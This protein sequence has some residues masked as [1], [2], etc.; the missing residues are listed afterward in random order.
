MCNRCFDGEFSR[1]QGTSCTCVVWL[2]APSSKLLVGNVLSIYAG[3]GKLSLAPSQ[4]LHGSPLWLVIGVASCDRRHYGL[5]IAYISENVCT[6]FHLFCCSFTLAF[7]PFCCSCSEPY[8]KV[9]SVAPSCESLLCGGDKR[10][11]IC[12]T[13]RMQMYFFASTIRVLSIHWACFGNSMAF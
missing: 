7:C 13:S 2:Y 6:H 9:F 1:L 3:F 12:M 5:V 8:L 11:Y 4:M 10:I